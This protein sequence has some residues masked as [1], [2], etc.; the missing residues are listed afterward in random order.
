ME[1]RE[2]PLRVWKPGN[3]DTWGPLRDYLTE[4]PNYWN[5]F[6]ISKNTYWKMEMAK[7]IFIIWI[8]PYCGWV[9][10]IKIWN[11]QTLKNSL[12]QTSSYSVDRS[13]KILIFLIFITI[14]IWT[15][16]WNEGYLAQLLHSLHNLQRMKFINL[17]V[18]FIFIKI[19]HL[20]SR[21]NYKNSTLY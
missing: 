18:H 19:T 4:Y 16:K 6:Q 17:M 11:A 21:L 10:H 9:F 14:K 1:E 13:L 2:N 20:F 8:V 12:N 7:I 15:I 3:V 5:Y